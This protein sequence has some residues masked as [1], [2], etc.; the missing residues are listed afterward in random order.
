MTGLE[1]E[2]VFNNLKSPIP[3]YA[4]HNGNKLILVGT[5]VHISYSFLNLFYGNSE[6]S[7]NM[8]TDVRFNSVASRNL[9]R[10]TFND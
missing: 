7:L 6:N 1:G 9:P 4:N 5:V 2:V 10:R 8:L 3:V